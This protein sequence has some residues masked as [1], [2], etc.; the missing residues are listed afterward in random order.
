MRL[1]VVVSL[2]IAGNSLTEREN[3]NANV[4]RAIKNQQEASL[5]YCITELKCYGNVQSISM[6]FVLLTVN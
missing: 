1:T 3:K 5:V 2:I 4:W 6:I